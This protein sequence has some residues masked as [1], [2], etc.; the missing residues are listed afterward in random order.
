MQK[1]PI[2]LGLLIKQYRLK[3]GLSQRGFALMLGYELPQFVSLFENGHSKIPLNKLG[4]AIRILN[5]PEKK[6]MEILI[7]DYKSEVAIAF[8]SKKAN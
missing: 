3:A 7:N 6:V 4:E 5:I 8:H 1:S 2:K